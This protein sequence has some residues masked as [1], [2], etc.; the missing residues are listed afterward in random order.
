[1]KKVFYELINYEKE[2]L[3]YIRASRK[4]NPMTVLEKFWKTDKAKKIKEEGMVKVSSLVPRMREIKNNNEIRKIEDI[5]SN[6]FL[7]E[8]FN[9]KDECYVIN[10]SVYK[11]HECGISSKIDKHNMKVKNKFNGFR[12]SKFYN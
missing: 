7:V 6:E 10:F 4:D 8:E 9:E 2:V 3:C 12:D 11:N 1:M 5:I